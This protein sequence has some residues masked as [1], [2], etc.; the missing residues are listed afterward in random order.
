L[1]HLRSARCYFPISDQPG[2]AAWGV[3]LEIAIR[4]MLAAVRGGNASWG[5]DHQW[6]EPAIC[7]YPALLFS[8]SERE[9]SPACLLLRFAGFERVGYRPEIR[10]VYRRLKVW[11]LIAG[12]EHRPSQGEPRNRTAPRADEIWQWAVAHRDT[13]WSEQDVTNAKHWLGEL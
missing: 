12:I 2:W 4:R 9:P 1:E 3:V 10:G 6:V 7:E 11:E 8:H 13:V 5:A